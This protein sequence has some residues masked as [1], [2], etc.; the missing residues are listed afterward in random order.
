MLAIHTEGGGCPYLDCGAGVVGVLVRSDPTVANSGQTDCVH[1]MH[2]EYSFD[3]SSLLG[4]DC[5]FI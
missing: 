4:I 2:F 5:Y 1:Q 3:V